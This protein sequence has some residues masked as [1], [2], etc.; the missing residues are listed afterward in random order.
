MT[1]LC[2]FQNLALAQVV[3][4]KHLLKEWTIFKNTSTYYIYYNLEIQSVFY[5]K[6]LSWSFHF[7]A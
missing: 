3:V 5:L 4:T 6:K 1:P 2:L 7:R